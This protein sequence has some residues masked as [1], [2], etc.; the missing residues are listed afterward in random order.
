MPEQWHPK[1]TSG[2]CGLAHMCA[3]TKSTIHG[4]LF[5]H[6][7]K[8]KSS[9]CLHETH[10]TPR[11]TWAPEKLLQELGHLNGAGWL[12]SREAGMHMCLQQQRSGRHSTQAGRVSG[13][14]E[15]KVLLSGGDLSCLS[16]QLMTRGDMEISEPGGRPPQ[17]ENDTGSQ[18]HKTKN[19]TV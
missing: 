1:L 12:V 19:G 3:H 18:A 5:L 4:L 15:S 17:Q 8:C 13:I 11:G 14:K 6:A 9:L 10:A 2:V 7:E 16:K